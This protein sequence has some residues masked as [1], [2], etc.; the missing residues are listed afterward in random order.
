MGT[1]TYA[2]NKGPKHLTEGRKCESAAIAMVFT[3][4]NKVLSML[5]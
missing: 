2:D 4:R 3:Y 5:A 1:F